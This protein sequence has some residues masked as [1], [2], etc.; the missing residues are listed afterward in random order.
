MRR[1]GRLLQSWRGVA[2]AGVAAPRLDTQAGEARFPSITDWVRS[3]VKGW[4][5]ADMIDDSQYARLQEA[6]QEQL[7][8]FAAAV[9]TVCFAAPAHVVTAVKTQVVKIWGVKT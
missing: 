8:S 6:A 7:Q 1:S 2:A 5:L 4:T 9:G 3:D